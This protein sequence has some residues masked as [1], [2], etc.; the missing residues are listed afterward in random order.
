MRNNG[1][2]MKIKIPNI[3]ADFAVQTALL[4]IGGTFCSISINSF[5][6]PHQFISGGFTG[7]AL[8]GYYLFPAIPVGIFYFCINI[9]AFFLGWHFIGLR[10]VLYTLWGIF[11]YSALLNFVNFRLEIADKLLS[12]MIAGAMTGIGTGITLYSKGSMGGATILSVVLNKL[13][14]ASIGTSTLI[15]NALVMVLASIFFP[16]EKVLYTVIFIAVSAKAAD[17]VFHGLSTRQTAIIISDHWETIL[18]DLTNQYKIGVTII[19]GKGGYEGSEKRIL[20]SVIN[21]SKVYHLKKA[22]MSRDPHAFISIIEAS[23]VTGLNI[24]NQPHW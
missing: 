19:D 10:F 2:Q 15:I 1:V 21:Q 13:F 22:V 4:L 24:G 17:V 23:D 20:F 8:I 16:I 5:L 7:F 6:I 3:V 11:I 12:A 14:S 9:P 18:D